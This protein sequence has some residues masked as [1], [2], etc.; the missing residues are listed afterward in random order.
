M[1]KKEILIN[2]QFAFFFDQPIQKPEDFW[3]PINTALGE[4]FNQTPIVQ[5]IPNNFEF[6][7]IP[8]VQMKSTSGVFSLNI[9]RGRV[10][11]FYTGEKDQKF[12]DIKDDFL[13]K[14]SILFSFLVEK[15]QKIKRI[16]FVTRNFIQDEKQDKSIALL[17]KETFKQIHD[18]NT[19]ETFIRYVSR[20][21]IN[22]FDINNFTTIEKFANKGIKG[23]LITRDFNTDP[24]KNYSDNFTILNIDLFIKEG[25]N[26][27]KF[28]EII[29]LL[30]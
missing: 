15:K 17:L 5:P 23:I 22:I 21:K 30:N 28:D 1:E 27:F 13:N 16:G 11:F 3:Q 18:G 7:E 29:K 20:D 24:E 10:D 9:S 2:S 19:F 4:I 8:V 12:L 26:K 25:E 14:I 6:N